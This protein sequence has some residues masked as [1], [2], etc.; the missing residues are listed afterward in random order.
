M[1]FPCEVSAV[2]RSL[3]GVKP[4]YTIAKEVYR[5]G[6]GLFTGLPVSIKFSPA[7]EG[8]GVV[9]Q[10]VDLPGRPL[11]PA[12]LQYVQGTPRCTILGKEGISIQMVE[13][14]LAS[15]AAFGIDNLLIEISGPEVPVFDGGS[16]AFVEMLEEAELRQQAGVRKIHEITAPVYWSQGDVHIVALPSDEYRISY[17]LHYPQSDLLHSQFYTEVINS[18]NFKKNIAPCRTFSLY[19]EIAPLIEK[20]LFK[21]GSLKNAVIIKEDKVLN[22]E[23]LR[24]PDEMVRHKILDVVGDLFLIGVPFKAHI[25]AIRSGHFSN[26]AFGVELFN[27]MQMESV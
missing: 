20:G 10:R 17:T 7:E 27:H 22:P 2:K 1:S 5:E 8:H 19:E 24:F 18:E 11:L 21:G 13:H 9:F 6:S 4:V 14:L 15:L 26:N 23:G 12:S 25:I 16:N 3:A